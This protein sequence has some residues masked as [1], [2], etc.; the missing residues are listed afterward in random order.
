MLPI[1]GVKTL[2]KSSKI[3]P[4]MDVPVLFKALSTT[5]YLKASLV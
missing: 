4:K 1:D 5:V 2:T 3:G